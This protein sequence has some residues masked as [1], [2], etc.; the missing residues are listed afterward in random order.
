MMISMWTNP[1]AISASLELVWQQVILCQGSIEH[2]LKSWILEFLVCIAICEWAWYFTSSA[3]HC[4]PVCAE[5]W[6]VS[7]MCHA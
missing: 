3:G 7:H 4:Q 2:F 6:A 5:K 1:V